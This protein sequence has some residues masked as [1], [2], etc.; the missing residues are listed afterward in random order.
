MFAD[1]RGILT[2]VDQE[3]EKI[4]HCAMCSCSVQLS[5][6][7]VSSPLSPIPMLTQHTVKDHKIQ[8]NGFQIMWNLVPCTNLYPIPPQ[9]SLDLGSGPIQYTHVSSPRAT[10]STHIPSFPTKHTATPH[11]L[12]LTSL[13][14][15]HLL[16]RRYQTR[17]CYCSSLEKQRINPIMSKLPQYRLPMRRTRPYLIHHHLCGLRIVFFTNV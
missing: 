5:P 10:V 1:F 2:F 13:L 7:C 4:S 14:I 17:R 6:R 9:K 8:C 12:F 16:H 11:L 3:L 15:V